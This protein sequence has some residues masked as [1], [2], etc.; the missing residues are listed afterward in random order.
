MNKKLFSQIKNEWRS[1]IWLFV[2]L[3]IVSVVMWFIVDY[4]YVQT[5]IYMA[6]R[7]FDTEHCYK[8][9]MG[10]LTDKSPDFKPNR[11]GHNVSE[12]VKELVKRLSLRPDVEAVGL[13]HNSHPYNG[14][15]SSITIELDSMQGEG[16]IYRRY[17]TPDFIRVFRYQGVRGESPEQLAA[18]LEE[19]TFFAS[20]NVFFARYN[21]NMTE[22]VGRDDFHL[23]GDTVE[24]YKLAASLLPIR[25]DDFTE[26]HNSR[27]MIGLIDWFDTYMEL[28]LRVYPDKDVDFKEKILQESEKQYRIGNVYISAINSFKDIRRTYQQGRMNIL[29]NYTFGIIFLLLNVFIGLLGTFWFR[30]HRRKSEIA[31]LM[32]VGATKRSVLIRLITEG[33]IILCLATIPAIIIDLNIANAELNAWRNSTTLE[34]GRFIITVLISFALIAFMVLIGIWIPASRAMKIEP[35]LALREE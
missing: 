4:V 26:A 7:G 2:E 32:S 16:F 25:Y 28:C 17:V 6:P 10:L 22:Y 19:K 11:T 9:S 18:M 29:R 31:L 20:D 1:N 30:T 24:H 5:T 15:N 13:A 27:S 3:L 14:N 23:F 33:F 35:A 21:K 34:T 8:I 12:D